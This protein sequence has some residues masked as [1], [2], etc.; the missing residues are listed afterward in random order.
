MPQPP[1]RHDAKPNDSVFGE[2]NEIDP[3][4]GWIPFFFVIAFVAIFLSAFIVVALFVR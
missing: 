3:T 4:P 1:T 2:S